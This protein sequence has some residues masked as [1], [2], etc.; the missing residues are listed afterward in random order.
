MI[1]IHTSLTNNSDAFLK[2]NVTELVT[3]Q[4][5]AVVES[6]APKVYKRIDLPDDTRVGFITQDVKQAI[7]KTNWNN[8]V[9]ST[10]ATKEHIDQEG[11]TVPATD[12]TL[13]LD[14]AR[15]NC[16]FWNVCRN[17]LNRVEPLKN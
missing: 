16:I 11:N 13:T 14:Y 12:S 6:V 10:E 4:A 8:I 17:L 7:N 3:D 2:T 5:I 1:T 9:G 15:L